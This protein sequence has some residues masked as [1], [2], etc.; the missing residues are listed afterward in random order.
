MTLRF[1]CAHFIALIDAEESPVSRALMSGLLCGACRWPSWVFAYVSGTNLKR[2][3]KAQ[4][5]QRYCLSCLDHSLSHHALQRF[6]PDSDQS[7]L[8]PPP[9]ALRWNVTPQLPL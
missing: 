6:L 3:L 8:R 7:G 4:A 2:V 9:T 5:S 1:R